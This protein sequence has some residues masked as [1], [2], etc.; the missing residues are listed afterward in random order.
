MHAHNPTSLNIR[1]L[2]SLA[3]KMRKTSKPAEYRK[4]QNQSIKQKTYQ[5]DTQ[6]A[7]PGTSP[8]IAMQF[9]HFLFAFLFY[10]F[11]PIPIYPELNHENQ[12]LPGTHSCPG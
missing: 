6:N 4:M 12:F 5:T 10:T 9:T 8:A 11:H 7:P 3:V 1:S 2:A